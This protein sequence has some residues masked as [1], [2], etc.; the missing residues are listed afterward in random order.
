MFGFSSIYHIQHLIVSFI[1]SP[2]FLLMYVSNGFSFLVFI[3]AIS[4]MHSLIF[5]IFN[6]LI[7][8]YG[9]WIFVLFIAS[10]F[11]VSYFFVFFTLLHK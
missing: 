7:S 10:L 1:V 11:F 5:F 9:F 2:S 8:F 6:R 3:F 4:Q